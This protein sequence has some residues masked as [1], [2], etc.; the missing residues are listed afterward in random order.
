MM[1]LDRLCSMSLNFSNIIFVEFQ[2]FEFL[3]LFKIE[4]KQFHNQFFID[5][6]SILTAFAPV[7]VDFEF[8][9]VPC[10]KLLFSS[11]SMVFQPFFDYWF[12]LDF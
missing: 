2:I 11:T 3:W 10:F 1:N 8:N 12:L 7:F 6:P 4:F 9:F 5:F